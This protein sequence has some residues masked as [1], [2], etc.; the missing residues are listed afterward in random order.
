MDKLKRISGDDI[1]S[2]EV[3]LHSGRIKSVSKPSAQNKTLCETGDAP[4]ATNEPFKEWL[5]AAKS[6]S[7]QLHAILAL[8][9]EGSLRISEVLQITCRDILPNKKIKIRTL[10]KGVERIISMGEATKFFEGKMFAPY[11]PFSGCSRFWVYREYKKLGINFKSQT[12]KKQS[13]T[14]AARHINT[15]ILRQ[16]GIDKVVIMSELGHTNTKTQEKYGKGK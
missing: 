13:V 6:V 7:P 9:I 2:G 1:L 5:R 14:H 12:S 4:G 10:K 16:T 8:Q 15:K 3:D 11:E